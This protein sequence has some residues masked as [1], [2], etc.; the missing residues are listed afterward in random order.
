MP[1]DQ[2]DRRGK[3]ASYYLFKYCLT[4]KK[5]KLK[6]E[7]WSY[8]LLAHFLKRYGIPMAS[9]VR[10]SLFPAHVVAICV[11]L[12]KPISLRSHFATVAF[13]SSGVSIWA[14]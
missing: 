11:A 5:R 1:I 10:Y 3:I 14:F 9:V 7:D 8:A 4:K 13:A 12:V 2:A 6:H